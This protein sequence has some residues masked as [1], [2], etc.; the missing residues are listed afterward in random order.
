MR[1]TLID[2]F[3]REASNEI[4]YE[5]RRVHAAYLVP[6]VGDR[7]TLRVRWVGSVAEPVQ[8]IQVHI[9]RG[10]FA[11]AGERS[12][13]VVLW[14]DTSPEIVDL[15]VIAKPRGGPIDVYLRNCWRGPSD[16]VR[17]SLGNAG[18]VVEQGDSDEVVLR[19]S[20]GEGAPDF[21]DLVVALSVLRPS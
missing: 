17:S 21:G 6:D 10:T 3:V 8:G 18:M 20:D 9:R 7:D 5:G 16:T 12:A 1:V 19:C 14:A 11:V 13:H 2:R 15:D 4:D